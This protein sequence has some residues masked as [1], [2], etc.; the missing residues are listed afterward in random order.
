MQIL[1]VDDDRLVA[2]AI[3]TL[4]EA[5]RPSCHVSVCCTAQHALGLLDAGTR[6]DLALVDLTMPG[7]DGMELLEAFKARDAPPRTVVMSA[8]D[9]DDTVRA[10]ADR[11]AV[12]FLA[13]ALP[14][15]A[16][17]ARF[18]QALAGRSVFPR[19]ALSVARDPPTAPVGSPAKRDGT[20]RL[21][22]R[23]R[24]ILHLVA[25]GHSNKRI[26]LLLGIAEATVKH[27][28]HQLFASLRVRNR[29]SCVR[30]ARRLALIDP[31]TE[32][33]SAIVR[34]PRT[35]E[36][37]QERLIAALGLIDAAPE[38]AYDNLVD[39]ASTILATPVALMTIVDRARDRQC[40][41]SQ[42]GVPEPWASRRQ[43]PLSYSFCRHAVDS[44]STLAV[45][46][47]RVHPLV[48]DNPAIQDFGAVAYL[49]A[50]IRG[51]DGRALGALC[52]IDTRARRWSDADV[53]VLERL[54][55]CASDAIELRSMLD[56][57]ERLR[58]EQA[59]LVRALG[60]RPHP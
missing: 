17:L 14:T 51:P 52:V 6:F 2:E 59:D 36:P 13:K 33:H 55:R 37:P 34:P 57:S 48:R 4:I 58:A 12:G 35:G 60:E 41:K 39:L 8:H 9:D 53:A 46:D 47:A 24:Q 15:A 42:T 30:E 40:F 1:V 49:G 38:A 29:T 54:A 10:A 27:H 3:A 21:G 11:G 25:D 7:I 23:Q 45:D 44:D 18:D 50:P 31:G 19:A 20:M 56:S 28:L 16:F 32:R 26:G 43:T 22:R 5:G